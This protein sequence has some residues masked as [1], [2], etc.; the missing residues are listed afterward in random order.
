MREAQAPAFHFT[1]SSEQAPGLFTI[2]ISPMSTC[3]VSGFVSLVVDGRGRL[4]DGYCLATI[5]VDKENAIRP[6]FHLR[7][8]ESVL[9]SVS[10]PS[11]ET[12]AIVRGFLCLARLMNSARIDSLDAALFDLMNHRLVALLDSVETMDDDLTL[13]LDDRSPFAFE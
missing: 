6:F 7:S 9:P 3:S 12:F 2:S 10:N 5:V 1:P 4:D 13:L 8:G 11:P